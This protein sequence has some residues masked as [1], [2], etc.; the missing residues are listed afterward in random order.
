MET[1]PTKPGY[2]FGND[3]MSGRTYSEINNETDFVVDRPNGMK[4]F[5]LNITTKGSG[6]LVSNEQTFTVEENDILLIPPNVPHYY[7]RNPLAQ[8]WER[9]WV[10]FRPRSHWEE[11]LHSWDSM[12]GQVYKTRIS[13]QQYISTINNKFRKIEK[14]I[15]SDLPFS[16]EIAY[17][18]LESLILQCNTLQPSIYGKRY[19]ERVLLV[20]DILSRDLNEDYSIETLSNKVGLS[21]SR[22]M[23]LFK[24]QVG[25]SI[26]KWRDMQRISC[27]KNMLV[28]TGDSISNISKLVGYSDPLYFSRIFK[29][30]AG[31]SPNQFKKKFG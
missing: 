12:I 27:A 20:I 2:I 31:L 11:W 10:Y 24:Q 25:M 6:L 23:S 14:N 21:E 28:N 26:L 5:T 7:Y 8:T 19:D 30:N 13:N 9:R 29:K 18:I 4:G 3:L 22:L 15:K 1:D 17:T 16:T